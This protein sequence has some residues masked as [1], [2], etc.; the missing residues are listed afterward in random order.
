MRKRLDVLAEPGEDEGVQDAAVSLELRTK[1]L[2][3]K[4]EL[5]RLRHPV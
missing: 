5:N 1:N 3:R 4:A 2:S